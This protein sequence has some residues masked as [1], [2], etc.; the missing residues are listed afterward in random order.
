MTRRRAFEGVRRF[1]T[2]PTRSDA[3][4]ARDV[5]DEVAFHLA[6]KAEELAAA[7]VA[8]EN[9]ARDAR[10]AFG[11]VERVKRALQEHETAFERWNRRTN[12]FGEWSRDAAH[13]L[14]QMRRAPSFAFL[15]VTT[16]GLGIGAT[17]AIFSAVHAILLAPLPFQAPERLVRV[18]R[19]TPSG[20]RQSSSGG[21]FLEFQRTA[22]AVSALAAYS[23]STGNLAGFGAPQRVVIT[24]VSANFLEVFGVRPLLGRS[25]TTAE[26]TYKAA[27]V[28]L[29]SEGAWQRL[30]G[31][32]RGVLG[33]T[34]RMDRQTVQIIGVVPDGKGFPDNAELWLP[35]KADPD[36]MADD[37][38]GA[39]W[40]RLI[41]RLAPGVTLEQANAEFRS[42]SRGIRERFPDLR[43]GIVSTLVPFTDSMLG[44]VRQPLW[45]LLGA[46][47][48]VLLLVCTNVAALMLG[49]VMAR[50]NEL[51]VRTALG[52]GRGRLARQLITESTTLG[53]VGAA[54]GAAMAVGLV[55][56]LVALAPDIPRLADVRVNALVLAFSMTL[57][58]LTGLAF[59]VI[60][61]WHLSRRDLQSSLR[62]SGRGLAGSRQAGR[63]RGALVV[64]QFALAIILLSGAG[65][66][67]RTFSGL[68]R[69]D[70]GFS[71]TNVTTF[72]VTLPQDG[73]FD[74][75][76]GGTAGQRQFLRTLLPK[77][78]G[79]PG[80]QVAGAT[81]GLPLSPTNFTLGFDVEGR[82]KQ[83]VGKTSDAQ[84]RVSTPGYFDA[85]EIPVVRGRALTATDRDGA[86]LVF[87]V[88]E[89][90]VRRYFPGE[91]VIG[92]RLTFSWSRDSSA[93]AGEVVGVVGDVKQL[94]LS[95]DAIPMAY[96]SADQW[97]V[98]E[99][100]FVLKSTLP[101]GVVGAA[102]ARAVKEVDA[103]LPLYDIQSA[104]ALLNGALA[105]TRFY[106]TILLVFATLALILASLGIYGVVSFGVQQRTREI[107]IRIA[108]GASLGLV[109]R[110]VVR[111]G[112]WLA[113]MG[114]VIGLAGA[115]A[116]TGVLRGVL[117][118]VQSTDPLT[119]AVVVALLTVAAVVACLLPAWRAARI[120]PQR[121]IRVD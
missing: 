17:T 121:A 22:R 100:T 59:G 38:R 99:L 114:V 108:L 91:D 28:A 10:R 76:Y 61:A 20:M 13:T 44:D 87:V 31:G 102:A 45:V 74:G 30:F 70:P 6:M 42:M 52:A 115:F 57:G 37:N 72:T 49:R 84:M 66:L 25:F 9:A 82:P 95:A 107:G 14:R 36:L 34:V 46:V 1:L 113:T 98:D 110:M 8:T 97:P 79:I 43:A 116:A 56:V 86:P 54:V 15:V 94:S 4:V 104:E 71:T 75:A 18:M 80:V 112:L 77:L 109:Q 26:D 33:R 32:D 12:W 88:S 51:T 101:V 63:M 81:M 29:I 35:L 120:D 55:R 67:L 39:S 7:G 60:P 23:I 3:Q 106:L 19:E 93:L 73:S 24:R 103:E 41:G 92:K 16:L 27:D 105:T 5:D 11:D 78:E 89:Q 85:M 53:V 96:V 119:Y 2:R 47:G 68:R 83:S 111:E 65:L 117:F 64:G 50:S 90:F 40:L 48:L 62:S 58:I 21:D 118:G 69:V